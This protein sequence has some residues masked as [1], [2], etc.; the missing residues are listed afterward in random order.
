MNFITYGDKK[1]KE[2]NKQPVIGAFSP[3]HRVQVFGYSD[4]NS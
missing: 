2:R 1:C 3:A 4:I